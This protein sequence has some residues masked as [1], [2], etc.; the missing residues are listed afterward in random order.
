MLCLCERLIGFV[1]LR[2]EISDLKSRAESISRQLRA[3]ADSLQNSDIRGQ[4]YLN[5]KSR[6]LAKARK[7]REEF[8]EELR[9][10]REGKSPAGDAGD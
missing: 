6:R 4:R 8:L 9:Q 3:W 1:D 10:I 2:T 5:E 7:E